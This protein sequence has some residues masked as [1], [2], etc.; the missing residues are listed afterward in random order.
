M[1]NILMSW[2]Y[3]NTSSRE[4]LGGLSGNDSDVGGLRGVQQLEGW[5]GDIR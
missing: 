2:P 5:G 4:N 1:I 3:L